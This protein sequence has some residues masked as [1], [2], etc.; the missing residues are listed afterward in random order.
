MEKGIASLN[1]LSLAIGFV[2][3]LQISH[4]LMDKVRSVSIRAADSKHC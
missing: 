3:G 1:Y 2:I 4:P